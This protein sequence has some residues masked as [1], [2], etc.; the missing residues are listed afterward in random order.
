MNRFDYVRPA[1]VA[2]AVAAAAAPGAAYLA[3]GTNLL[4]LMQGNIVRPRRI[5]D[6]T[7]LPGLD[8]ITPL[9]GG[10]RGAAVRRL[11]AVAQRRHGGRQPLAAH[12]LRLVP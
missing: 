6:V 4:D 10:R 1:T 8:A 9:P 3:G 5:V 7:R 2:E 11:A 12:A